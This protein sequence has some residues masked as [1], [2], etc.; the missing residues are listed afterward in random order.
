V[1]GEAV[2]HYKILSRLGAGGMGVVYE[3]EDTRLG[4]KVAIKFLPDET[5]ADADTIQRFQREARVISNLNHPYIC[6]LYDI[7]THDGRQFMVMELLDGQ[8]LKDRIARGGLPLD[9]VLELGAQMADA[10]DAAHAQGVVHRDIKPANLFVIRRGMIKVLDFGVAKLNE[11]GRAGAGDLGATLGAADHLTT[12]GTTIG[13]VA[14]MSPEQARGQEIDA[15]SDLFSAGVVLYEMAT[16]QLP[17]QG[18]TAATIFEGLLTRQPTPPSQIKAGI[19]AELDRIILK[20]LEK[21]RET[22]YQGAAELRADL[23]RLKRSAESGAISATAAAVPPPPRSAASR[24]R[25]RTPVFIG[26]PLLTAALAA[27]FFFYRSIDTPALTEK[28]TVVLSSIVNRTGDTMFDDTLGEGLALQVRQSPFLNVVPDQQVQATLRLMGR[29]PMTAITAEVGR[30]VCQRAGAKALLG[31]TIAMLGSA[32]V[33]TLHAQDCVEGKV[34]AEE[35]AQASSKENV[36][37]VLGTTVSAFREKLGESLA[38]IQRYD[39]KIE[40]A[41]TKSLEALK[42]YSQGLRTRRMTGDFDSVPFFR[43]AIDLDPEFALAYARLGTVYANLQQTDEARKMTARAYELRQRTSEAERLYIEARYYST[44]EPDV[45]KALDAY[46]VWLATYP[47]DYTALTNSALLHKQQGDRAEALRKL[48]RATEAAPDQPLAWT[49]LGQTYFEG[50]E[51]T[52]AKRV[53]ETAIKLQDSTSARIGLY[54]V[55]ILLGDQPL[56]DQ[57]VAAVRGRRDEADMVGIRMFAAT[58]RGRM[59]E[60]SELATE[61]QA[62][63]LALSRGPAAGN[64]LLQVAISEALVGMTEQAKARVEKAEADGLV[65]EQFVEARLVVAAIAQDAPEARRLLPIAQ[66]EVKKAAG[67]ETAKQLRV[68]EA[69]V[70]L[71][72]GKFAAAATL[73]EPVTFD[74]PNT[75]EVNI[76]TVARLLAGD[77]SSALKGLEFMTSNQARGGLSAT[78]PWATATLARV[79]SELGQKDEARKTYQKFFELWKDADPDVPLL[80]RAREEFGKPGS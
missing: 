26:A 31:G 29:E 34:L 56:A 77:L 19:P 64:G 22:R 9:D 58:Y 65:G 57:Q 28:D 11:A 32:Y 79:Q 23:K 72:E 70:A 61:F 2:S 33:I 43:R 49:N 40:E 52:E 13:T 17:F 47:N 75:N 60:A 39:A 25:W 12:I 46:R 6:T 3:A 51:Y 59:K 20:A 15:R 74:A 63:A 30:E 53:M 73:M 66:A 10:L 41:T 44:V 50:A 71:A 69:L 16:G 37:A 36:L 76:W 14:Y 7:G 55:A 62:R 35:Q 24:P 38:S 48:Q 78:T 54:Q 27:G 18:A 4:R 8:P 45:Q 5:S 80:V 67:P 21:D 1:I 68:L 42:A